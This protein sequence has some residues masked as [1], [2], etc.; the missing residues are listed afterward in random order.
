MRVLLDTNILIFREDDHEIPDTVQGL[1]SALGRL[2]ADVLVHPASKVDINKDGMETRRRKM[3]SKLGAYQNLEKSPD[4]RGDSKFLMKLYGVETI[5]RVKPDDLI[6]YSIYRNAAD[7]LITEDMGI[8]K[9]ANRLGV[10]DRILTVTEFLVFVQGLLPSE[11]IV[12]PPAIMEEA[13]HNLDLEDPI[14]AQL[15]EDYPEFN[16]WFVR[17]SREGRKCWISRM[18]DGNL[19][20][21]LIWKIE[22]DIIDPRIVLPKKRRLKVCTFK[23]IQKGQK[24]GELFIRMSIDYACQNGIEEIFLTH[25]I[26]DPNDSLSQLLLEF[27]FAVEGENSRGEDVFVKRLLTDPSARSSLSPWEIDSRYFPS[28]YDGAKVAKFIVP[29]RPEYHDRL[30]MSQERRQTFLEE[31]SGK[32]IVEG[33]TIKKAYLSN[34]RTKGIGKG[35]IVLFYRS[36]DVSMVTDL[37]IVESAHRFEQN[38]AGDILGMVAKRT[39]YSYAEIAEISKKQTLVLIFRNHFHLPHPI[40]LMV[41]IDSGVVK[42]AP[43]TIMKITGDGYDEIRRRGGIDERYSVH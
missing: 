28:F 20:A 33:N 36:R 29:I 3:L 15:R 10:S 5:D 7:F 35:D 16:D 41:L 40:P 26:R 6:I 19:G 38:H 12:K 8:H 23:V 21:L 25:F 11:K 43:Q 22:D 39:V 14:F 32:F 2:K 30:F 24:I 4:P 34:S 27:G 17:I 31:Y 18:E 9:K 42:G 13:A 37:G 1:M